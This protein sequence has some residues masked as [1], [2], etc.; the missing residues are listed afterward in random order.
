MQSSFIKDFTL[1]SSMH[2][3]LFFDGLR[4]YTEASHR[5]RA[6]QYALISSTCVN[7]LYQIIIHST[8]VGSTLAWINAIFHMIK[9]HYR[10][11]TCVVDAYQRF[12][13]SITLSWM[14][15]IHHHHNFPM[16]YDDKTY[17]NL[18]IQSPIINNLIKNFT[19][20]HLVSPTH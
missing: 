6:R 4:S 1:F 18:T 15:W 8:S 5:F 14:F 17:M 7:A 11:I 2:L 3:D 12:C 10:H 20:C 9:V 19:P 13:T 16:F